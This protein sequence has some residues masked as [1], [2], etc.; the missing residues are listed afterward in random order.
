MS[1]ELDQSGPEFPDDELTPMDSERTIRAGTA[2]NAQPE[3][4][5]EVERATSVTDGW[6]TRTE[7]NTR[8]FP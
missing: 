7:Y 2:A 1:A 6:R 4:R 5:G 3:P 8:R